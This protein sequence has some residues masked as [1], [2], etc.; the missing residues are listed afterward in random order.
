MRARLHALHARRS[1]DLPM[2]LL[3]LSSF[4]RAC[5]DLMPAQGGAAAFEPFWIPSRLVYPVEGGGKPE[6]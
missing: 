5:G 3:D 1:A 2:N 4:L 6:T